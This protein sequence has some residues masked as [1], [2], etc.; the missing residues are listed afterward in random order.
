MKCHKFYAEHGWRYEDQK[1]E[2]KMAL[3]KKNPRQVGQGNEKE[4]SSF[5]CHFYF[6]SV[7]YKNLS[8]A[9][10]L[11]SRPVLSFYVLF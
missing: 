8:S 5:V 11:W 1:T 7:Y 10:Q 3:E 9:I 4:M 6:Y 2:L